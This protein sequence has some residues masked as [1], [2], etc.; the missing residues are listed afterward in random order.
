MTGEKCYCGHA[1]RSHH[2][3][4]E[5]GGRH[6]TGCKF[7]DCLQYYPKSYGK[8]EWERLQKLQHEVYGNPL[9]S[10]MSDKLRSEGKP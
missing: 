5:S 3:R 2:S 4:P 9:P 8:E 10:I 6:Y 7:C 1:Q